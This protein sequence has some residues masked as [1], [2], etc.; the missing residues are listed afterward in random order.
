MEVIG[1]TID[2]AA[3]EAFDK[4][5]KLLGF[6]YPGGPFVDKFAQEGNSSAFSFAKPSIKGYDFSFSGLKTSI[7]YFLQKQQ[8]LDPDF[9]EKNKADLCASIQETV[10]GILM[11]KLL[12]AAQDYG[13]NQLAIAGG[14]S[15]NSGLRTALLNLEKEKDFQVFIPKFDYCTDN[16]A[17][18]AITAKYMFEKGIFADQQVAATARFS[19]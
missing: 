5:A 4:A 6:P 19:I 15:A 10:I 12:K 18:I 7:L 8:M 16:A 17:M 1:T 3:G 14:V 2:D 11:K 13:I 9:I